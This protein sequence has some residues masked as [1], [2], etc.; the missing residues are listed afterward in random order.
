MLRVGS[1][2]SSLMQG[3]SEEQQGQQIPCG[4]SS[5]RWAGAKAERTGLQLP[6]RILYLIL[7]FPKFSVSK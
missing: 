4:T 6:A 5:T 7:L 1:W 2:L 3:W